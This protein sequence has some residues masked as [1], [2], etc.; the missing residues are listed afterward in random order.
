MQNVYITDLAAFLPNNPVTNEEMEERLGMNRGLP[1]R[2]KKIILASNGI[3]TRYYAID[4]GSREITHTNARLAA[5]A[6]RRLQPFEDFTPKNIDC[7]CCGS[8]SPDQLMPGHASMVHAE[9]GETPCEI[10]STAGICLS[11]VTALKYGWMNVG[12]GLS[13]NAV[14]TGS[15][16]ASTFLRSEFLGKRPRQEKIDQL[17]KKPALSFEA[18][19]LRWMLSDGAGAAFLASEPGRKS[20]SLK[21]DW[22]D[23]VSHAHRR[24]PCMYAGACKDKKGHFTGWR[25]CSSLTDALNREFFSVKQD[26]RLLNR[27]ILTTVVDE[28]LPRIIETHNL[29]PDDISWFLPHYSSDYFRIPLYEHLAAIGFTIPYDRWFTNLAYKGNTGSASI[30]IIMEELLKSGR[31]RQG[32]S[33]MCFIPESGRFSTAYMHLTVV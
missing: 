18:D 29:N 6:I 14:A 15:E 20:Q 5:E 32:E 25:E 9:L 13:S 7:L 23:I 1:S 22:I 4:P 21:I 19:F 28:S 31:L 10:V 3:N 26:A 17:G 24:E 33:I 16:L 30:Y 8:S 12:T 11:G 2:T 27:L